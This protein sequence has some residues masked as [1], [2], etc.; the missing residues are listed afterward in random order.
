M[1]TGTL[2]TAAGFLPI[3][4]ANSSTGE[5]TRAIFQ[6]VTLALLLSWIAAVVFVPYL[7]YKLLPERKP[8]TDSPAFGPVNGAAHDPYDTAFY[9]RFRGWVGWCL[10]HR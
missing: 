4:T 2:V 5:Y 10:R 9:R 8:V 3:A 7:G 6:V 1:L